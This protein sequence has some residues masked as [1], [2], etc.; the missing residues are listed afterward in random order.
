MVD[1]ILLRFAGPGEGIEEL[2]WGQRSMWTTIQR[3][4][5]SIRLGGPAPQRPGT[6][7]DELKNRYTFMMSR[8]PALRTRLVFG[9]DGSVRQQLFSSGTI[10]LT[11]LEAGDRQERLV[12]P[13]LRL[14]P[15]V[16]PL[17]SF[18]YFQGADRGRFGKLDLMLDDAGH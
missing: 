4:G 6:T 7:L 18:R 14:A 15:G 11:V 17:L 5:Q 10:E 12:D 16:P 2:S 3:E 13:R 8:H 1:R 9:P